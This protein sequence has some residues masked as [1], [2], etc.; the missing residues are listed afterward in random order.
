LPIDLGWIPQ[1]IRIILSAGQGFVLQITPTDPTAIP[2]GTTAVMNLYPPE[3]ESLPVA[4]WPA[5][6][7]SWDAS[8]SE[9]IVSWDVASGSADVIP[10]F[11]FVRI[12]LT[13]VDG[14]YVWAK[15]QVDRND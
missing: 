13:Y 6:I 7:D 11:A 15:G 5:P 3:T 2:D 14:S 12:I 10:Q 4:Y 1:E 8:I 9:G